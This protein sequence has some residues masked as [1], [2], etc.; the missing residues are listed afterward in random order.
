MSKMLRFRD[1]AFLKVP[2]S[3]AKLALLARLRSLCFTRNNKII[4]TRK[5]R[6][7]NASKLWMKLCHRNIYYQYCLTNLNSEI[8]REEYTNKENRFKEAIMAF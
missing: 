3:Q 7:K 4:Q 5:M 1:T 6:S 8:I 2:I